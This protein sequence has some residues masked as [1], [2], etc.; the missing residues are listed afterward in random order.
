[1]VTTHSE[2]GRA[3]GVQLVEPPI[4]VVFHVI[5]A[6]ILARNLFRRTGLSG[7]LLPCCLF[8]LQHRLEYSKKLLYKRTENDVPPSF[9]PHFRPQGISKGG[10]LFLLTVGACLLTVKLLCL[11]SL[12]TLSRCTFPL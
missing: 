9:S 6:E 8:V 1:M 7:Q 11:Q 3:F 12:K 5:F 2:Y 4:S 10:K